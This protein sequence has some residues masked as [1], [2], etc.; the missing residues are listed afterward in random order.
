MFT[1]A[2]LSN[3]SN[4]W[5]TPQYIFDELDAEFHFTLDPCATEE[6]AKCEKFFTKEQDGLAQTWGG[7]TGLLQSPLRAGCIPVGEEVPR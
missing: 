7:R 6:N 1:K 2:M 4:E 3:S 5:A